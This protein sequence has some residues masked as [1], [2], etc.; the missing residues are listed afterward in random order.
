MPL[1]ESLF[2]WVSGVVLTIG[3]GLLIPILISILGI[4][5][6]LRPI[7]SLVNSVD[8]WMRH[9]GLDAA[10]LGKIAGG[11]TTGQSLP[12]EQAAERDELTSSARFRSLT[13]LEATRLQQLLREDALNDLAKGAIGVLA[14]IGIMAILSAIAE[15]K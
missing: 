15:K 9:R 11:D 6:D 4:R 12:S 10:I 5:G 8:G 7:T 14:F 2:L 13:E 3:L 1:T